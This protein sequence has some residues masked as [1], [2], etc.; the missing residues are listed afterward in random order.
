MWNFIFCTHKSTKVKLNHPDMDCV[1]QRTGLQCGQCPTG[2]SAVFGSF[3]CKKC[4]NDM[5]W[6]LSVFF[7]AGIL[8]VFCLFT[9][10]M[11]VGDGKINAVF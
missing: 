5:L 1:G 9:L 6:L 7:I 4:S 3:N 2:L 10:N 8:F 11:T